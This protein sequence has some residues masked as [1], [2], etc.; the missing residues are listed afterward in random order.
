MSVSINFTGVSTVEQ[1]AVPA[2]QYDVSVAAVKQKTSKTS[3]EPMLEFRL[4]I[5]SGEYAGR[6]L[7]MNLMLTAKGLPYL[8]TFLKNLGFTEE[9]L[10]GQFELDLETLIGLE[11]IAVVVVRQNE[12]GPMNNVIRTMPRTDVP[13]TLP[14]WASGNVTAQDGETEDAHEELD[15]DAD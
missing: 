1:G 10:E 13:A 2:G 9:E 14:D 3:Q 6:S 5:E 12:M 15:L 8:K 7:F 4:Q 11:C